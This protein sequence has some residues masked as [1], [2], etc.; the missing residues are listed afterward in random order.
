MKKQCRR[1]SVHEIDVFVTNAEYEALS[2][3]FKIFNYYEKSHHT[4]ATVM[5]KV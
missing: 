5:K 1:N 4:F 2:F 3:F